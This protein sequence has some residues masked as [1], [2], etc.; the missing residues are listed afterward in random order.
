MGTSA[1]STTVDRSEFRNV[2][3]SGAKL[4]AI[5][6]VSVVVFSWLAQTLPAGVV[7]DVVLA[8]LVLAAGTLVS[9]LPSQW[10]GARSVEGVAGAAA[11]GLWGT[12]VFMAIDVVLFRPFDHL[13]RITHF[14]IYPWTWDALGGMSTW[15]Y[16]PIWWML[17]TFVAWMGGLLTAARASRGSVTLAG[18]ALP[19][20]AGAA[21]IAG[22]ARLAGCPV[23]V[24]ATTAAGFTITLTVLALA[25]AARKA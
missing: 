25:A 17:G 13:L 16:L 4:G 22:A 5:T 20:V 23:A 8:I 15:W 24:P 14:A 21:I 3:L 2:M 7:R 6:A 19:V 11:V 9:L 1:A 10:V 18:L 12:V